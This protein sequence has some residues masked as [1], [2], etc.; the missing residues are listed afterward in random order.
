MPWETDN[1]ADD[2]SWKTDFKEVDDVDPSK[3]SKPKGR[4]EDN[5][6]SS[7]QRSRQIVMGSRSVS[8]SR[9]YDKQARSKSPYWNGDLKDS[10]EEKISFTAREG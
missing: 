1:S 3:S 9:C 8:S 2:E 7:R 6:K 5:Q 4:M 10:Y